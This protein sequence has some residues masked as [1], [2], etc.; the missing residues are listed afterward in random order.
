MAETKMD[1]PL[2]IKI[3]IAEREYPMRADAEVE[4]ILRQAGKKINDRIQSYREKYNIEDRQDLLSMVALECMVDFLK[5]NQEKQSE[6]DLMNQKIS[7]WDKLI[8][9]ALQVD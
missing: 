2:F 6:N 3:K 4:A 1:D 8:S 5:L 9:S 7:D